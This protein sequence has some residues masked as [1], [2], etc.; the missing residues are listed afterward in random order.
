MARLDPQSECD[1]YGK[2]ILDNINSPEGIPVYDII[3][4]GLGAD[5]H[6]ASIF[7]EQIHLFDSQNICETAVIP[8][9]GQQRITITGKVINHAKKA[10]LCYS[11]AVQNPILSE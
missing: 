2:L 7:P 10:F 4:L 1:R 5:G 8:E 3:I 9:T 6:I 11:M